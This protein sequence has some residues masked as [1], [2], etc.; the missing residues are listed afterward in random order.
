M[1]GWKTEDMLSGIE[2]VMNLAARAYILNVGSGRM[3]R[4]RRGPI[5]FWTTRRSARIRIRDIRC[6][7]LTARWCMSR[8]RRSLR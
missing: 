2:G 8:K 7:M 6:S 1:A 5:R 4:A 3:Q